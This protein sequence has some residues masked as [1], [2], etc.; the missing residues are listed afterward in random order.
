MNANDQIKFELRERLK[1]I[2][3]LNETTVLLGE[4]GRDPEETLSAVIICI[5][6]AFQFPERISAELILGEKN[7]QT[8]DYQ[9]TTQFLREPVTLNRQIMGGL[10]VCYT[11]TEKAEFLPRRT[12]SP[13]QP[14]ADGSLLSKPA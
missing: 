3:C 2:K 13:A 14:C 1:E 9:Q 10:T 12:Q 5:R 7:Y 8:P 4:T 6:A 11:G